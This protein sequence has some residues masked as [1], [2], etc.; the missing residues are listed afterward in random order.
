[1]EYVAYGGVQDSIFGKCICTSILPLLLF[2]CTVEKYMRTRKIKLSFSVG[3]EQ[4]RPSNN[5]V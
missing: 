1:M 4:I 5:L 3:L 2:V